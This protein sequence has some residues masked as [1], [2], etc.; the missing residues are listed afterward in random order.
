[1]PDNTRP[2]A[3]PSGLPSTGP[4]APTR[5]LGPPAAV[6]KL[7]AQ[8]LI[9]SLKKAGV[10]DAT[11]NQVAQE[12]AQQQEHYY[13]IYGYVDTISTN[14]S[15]LTPDVV[16]LFR[17]LTPDDRWNIPPVAVLSFPP[18]DPKFLPEFARTQNYYHLRIQLT[19]EAKPG[20]DMMVKQVAV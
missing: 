9:A 13:N 16:V 20:S 8:D 5:T 11:A 17:R 18:N 7:W 2:T 1:M 14:A 15:T 12:Q 10:S 19:V 3:T 4:V 6:Q